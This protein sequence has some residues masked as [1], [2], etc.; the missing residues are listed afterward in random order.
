MEN[1][2][3]LPRGP[4]DEF[5][6]DPLWLHPLEDRIKIHYEHSSKKVKNDGSTLRACPV[7]NHFKLFD[8]RM[9]LER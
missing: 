4:R 9:L 6:P 8:S 2:I 3:N 5:S 1:R 7:E